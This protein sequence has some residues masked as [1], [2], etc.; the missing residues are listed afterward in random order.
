MARWPLRFVG[1]AGLGR[2][3]VGSGADSTHDA[4]MDAV[5]R[6]MRSVRLPEGYYRRNRWSRLVS[7]AL[8][9]LP[10]GS[11]RDGLDVVY[12]LLFVGCSWANGFAG[13]SAKESNQRFCQIVE[14]L[15]PENSKK[16]LYVSPA[17]ARR[18]LGSTP[19]P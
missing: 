1:V 18:T 2:A 10:A 3:V 12:A 8:G 14:S 19:P 17:L 7:P 16:K 11:R 4:S 6:G 5:L 9:F 15:I 13:F